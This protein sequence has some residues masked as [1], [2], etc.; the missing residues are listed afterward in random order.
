MNIFLT[1]LDLKEPEGWR[2][3]SL[4]NTLL[5]VGQSFLTTRCEDSGRS[6]YHP[7]ALESATDSTSGVLR[8]G[9]WSVGS[10]CKSE[11]VIFSDFS[12]D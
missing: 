3:S 6:T 11:T 2:F 1:Y 4:R 10:S 8:H 7:A 12:G 9:R 5:F